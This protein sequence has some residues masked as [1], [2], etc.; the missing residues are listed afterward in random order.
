[1][2]SMLINN[3]CSLNNMQHGV[4]VSQDSVELFW[5]NNNLAIFNKIVT[6][7]GKMC[8]VRT[9]QNVEK[10]R[11]QKILVFKKNYLRVSL[12]SYILH[13]SSYVVFNALAYSQLQ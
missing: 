3:N 12:Y 6:G 9:K 11:K 1:M 5:I 13:A 2:A 10:T 8:I 4:K 7:F